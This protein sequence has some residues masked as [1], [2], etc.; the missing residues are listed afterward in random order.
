MKAP[1]TE[2]GGVGEDQSLAAG[3]AFE[4]RQ[5]SPELRDVG[6][7]RTG[8]VKQPGVAQVDPSFR[9]TAPNVQ[10]VDTDLIAFLDSPDSKNVGEWG[11]IKK[12]N[13]F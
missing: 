6:A 8:A 7:P 11:S 12:R 1:L 3:L 9:L 5:V 13:C 2:I 4:S 10:I